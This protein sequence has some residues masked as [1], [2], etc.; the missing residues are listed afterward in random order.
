M[1][2]KLYNLK[3]WKHITW[4]LNNISKIPKSVTHISH[5]EIFISSSVEHVETLKGMWNVT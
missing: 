3:N 4:L 5:Y 2:L 1:L